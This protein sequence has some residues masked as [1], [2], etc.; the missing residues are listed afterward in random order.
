MKTILITG[1][2]GFI[3]SNLCN[4]LIKDYNIICMDN[5]YTGNETNIY[6]LMNKPNFKLINQDIINPIQLNDDIDIIFNLACPASPVKYQKNP[7]H[8][9]KT[10]TIG[11]MNVLDLAVKNDSK[12]IHASTSEVY[13]NPEIHPQHEKYNG[14]INTTNI[15][16]C[17]DEGKRIG[18]TLIF[19]YS[20]KYN[21]QSAIVRIFNTYGVNMDKTDGRVVS[22]FINQALKNEPLTIYGDGTQTRSLMYI[23]DLIKGLISIMENID[24]FDSPVNIGNPYEITINDL[25]DKIINLTN[26][27]SEKRYYPLPVA[28][29]LRRNPDI[30]LITSKIKWKPKV[31]LNEGLLKTI[32]YYK[33]VL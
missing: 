31:E 24:I 21:L 22:N 25:A 13:G 29:P 27:S 11:L 33:R 2:A 30:N 28:D 12:I 20:R 14:N 32:N 9:I 5:F 19:E 1:G 10:C 4:A 17:Y 7:I 8:T 16:S 15:R 3:G 26:S 18:E 23:S 6:E